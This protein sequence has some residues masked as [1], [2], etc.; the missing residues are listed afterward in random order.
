MVKESTMKFD[1]QDEF[2]ET[3]TLFT[4]DKRIQKTPPLLAVGPHI[5]DVN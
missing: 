4:T 1:L 5:D 2:S 3:L